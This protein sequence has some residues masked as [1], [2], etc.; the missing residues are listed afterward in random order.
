MKGRVEQL[1]HPSNICQIYQTDLQ[2]HNPV[3][4]QL[5]SFCFLNK[6]YMDLLDMKKK[7]KKII[8]YNN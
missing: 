8:I 6:K 1:A 7:G 5:T 4:K 2:H 3:S